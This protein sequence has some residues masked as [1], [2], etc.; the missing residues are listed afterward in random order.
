MDFPAPIEALVYTIVKL[1][2]N[3]EG[4]RKR[5]VR[6]LSEEGK[7]EVDLKFCDPLQRPVNS[8]TCSHHGCQETGLDSLD[9]LEETNSVNIDTSEFP[10]KLDQ[11]RL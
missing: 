8:S 2:C 5:I 10:T 6:C 9:D 4:T 7:L 11:F 3:N 1:K